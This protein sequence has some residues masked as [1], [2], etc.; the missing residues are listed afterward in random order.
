[1]EPKTKHAITFRLSRQVIS[2]NQ[3]G[4]IKKKFFRKM[5]GFPIESHK[6]PNSTY[7]IV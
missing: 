6:C 1:M 7:S 2:C 4:K 3:E 5:S